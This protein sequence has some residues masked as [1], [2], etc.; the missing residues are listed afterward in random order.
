MKPDQQ[1][2]GIFCITALVMGLGLWLL[3]AIAPSK[4]R[5]AK[6]EVTS[7]PVVSG[8]PIVSPDPADH[9]FS[10][11]PSFI[12]D[13][14]ADSDT[15]YD[16][17]DLEISPEVQAIRTGEFYA[18][19]D[20]AANPHLGLSAA[21]AQIFL[22]DMRNWVPPA[23]KN[24]EPGQSEGGRL[25]IWQEILSL[26]RRQDQ[27]KAQILPQL[28]ETT[29]REQTVPSLRG[30]L[31]QHLSISYEQDEAG[32]YRPEL[33]ALFEEAAKHSHPEIQGTALLALHRLN[34]TQGVEGKVDPAFRKAALTLVQ[35]EDVHPQTRISALQICGKE[36]VAQAG[37]IAAEL[38]RNGPTTGLR[39]AAIC[40][41][42][43]LQQT[44]QI[45]FL[46]SLFSDPNQPR[47]HHPARAALARLK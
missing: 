3:F 24:H 5:A 13:N 30:Y 38:A 37:N 41:L 8:R 31:I 9:K 47:L 28:M 46:E 39:I 34:G 19:L 27:L 35:D 25:V 22:D 36:N 40:T 4:P 44:A 26:L 33:M 2:I 7:D 23:S 12:S 11:E 18:A 10:A 45:P 14:L 29:K 20:L 1:R 43:D 17:G 15:P 21:E 16:D 6:P 42:A 32:T